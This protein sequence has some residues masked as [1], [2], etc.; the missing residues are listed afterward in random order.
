M[1]DIQNLMRDYVETRDAMF[2][3]VNDTSS[4]LS[5]K[6]RIKLL[7]KQAKDIL[8]QIDKEVQ[9]EEA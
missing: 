8:K 9:R 1:S 4:H 7:K 6:K 3:L 2:R 5:H